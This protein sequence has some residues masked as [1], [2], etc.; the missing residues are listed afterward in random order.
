MLRLGGLKRKDTVE[1]MIQS[2]GN[3]CYL[4]MFTGLKTQVLRIMQ[5]MLQVNE[6]FYSPPSSM[7]FSTRP[8]S[9]MPAL[10]ITW[11]VWNSVPNYR[12]YLNFDIPG[13]NMFRWKARDKRLSV[14]LDNVPKITA[15]LYNLIVRN[16][17]IRQTK[18]FNVTVKLLTLFIEECALLIAP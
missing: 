15:V 3:R 17:R 14:I 10:F 18:L 4:Y 13:P 2:R 7:C 11:F 9:G 6:S 12:P 5:K 1:I 8:L 16:A